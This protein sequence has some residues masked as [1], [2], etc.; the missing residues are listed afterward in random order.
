MTR[1]R[2][3]PRATSAGVVDHL[4][5]GDGESIGTALDDTA[6]GVADQQH[7]DASF[8]ENPREG[9]VVSGQAGDLLAALLHFHYMRYGDLVAHDLPSKKKALQTEPEG[10]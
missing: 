10:Q 9:I 5:H 7:L 4:V 1:A 3:R 6:Q 2:L 8:V